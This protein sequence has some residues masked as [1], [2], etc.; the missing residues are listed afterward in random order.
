MFR[1]RNFIEVCPQ[2]ILVSQ[3]RVSHRF[4]LTTCCTSRVV[5]RLLEILNRHHLSVCLLTER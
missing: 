4:P 5:A 1:E 2:S 3:T